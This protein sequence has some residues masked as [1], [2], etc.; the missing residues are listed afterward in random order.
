M[1]NH[2]LIYL[3]GSESDSNSGTARL[4]REWFPGVLTPD[5][6][7]SF[8]NL[9]TQLHTLVALAPVREIAQKLFTNLTCHIV[10]DDHRL[11]KTV[12]ELDWNAILTKSYSARTRRLKC[13]I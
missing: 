8:A 1:L 11:H 9:M 7:E 13:L 5:S 2:K 10:E 4:F 12:H 3:R 6:T